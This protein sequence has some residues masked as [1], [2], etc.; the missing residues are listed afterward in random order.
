MKFDYHKHLNDICRA[1]V[2]YVRYKDR[3]YDASWKEDGGPGAYFTMKR[4]ID[5]FIA[6]AKREQYDIFGVIIREGL[7][8]PDGSLIACVRDARR[9]LL[10]L[11]AELTEQAREVRNFISEE[12]TER[13]FVSNSDTTVGFG[14]GTPEDGGHHARQPVEDEQEQAGKEAYSGGSMLLDQLRRED[15]DLIPWEVGWGYLTQI[16]TE[17]RDCWVRMAPGIFV[18]EPRITPEQ[19]DQLPVDVKNLYSPVWEQRHSE[20][21][22]FVDTPI[23]IPE[24][25]VAK[26]QAFWL[27]IGRAPARERYRTLPYEQNLKEAEDLMEYIELYSWDGARQRYVLRRKEWMES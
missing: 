18:L 9:Y 25:G 24:V 11:E 13:L 22:T 20:Y 21:R 23:M 17:L 16:E 26:P 8:G 2:E 1:D 3:H 19:H 7:E 27:R 14:P 15:A 5:R 10:L 6:I 12:P 4:P